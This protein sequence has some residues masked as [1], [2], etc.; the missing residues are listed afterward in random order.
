M[1][2]KNPKPVKRRLFNTYITATV[3][4]A[5][6]LFMLGSLGLVLFNARQ[7]SD[8][9]K[10]N[11][12]FTLMLDDEAREPEIV[13]LQKMIRAGGYAKST[14]YIDKETAASELQYELGE[15]FVGFLG[16]NPLLA[17]VDVKL[18]ARYMHPDTLAVLEKNFLESPIVNEVYYQ[19]D[20][21]S[22]INDNLNKIGVIL[23]VTSGMLLIIFLALINNIIRISI[24]S[25]RFIINTMQLVGATRSFIRRPF[26]NKSITAGAIGA[27]IANVLLAGII[28]SYQKE[29]K[30]IIDLQDQH[31]LLLLFVLVFLCGIF[32]SWISTRFAVNK[33]LRLKF[34]ELFY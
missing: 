11:V 24:Y 30:G 2:K 29:L 33:F 23:L 34:D 17:S 21:V 14:R 6:V 32:I 20:L 25:Q 16:Y 12:G 18:H 3:S 26:L 27:I 5:M 4:I 7:I 13:H 19:H 28:Y 8:Y 31:S 10:E 15:D 1:R 22:L 9:V